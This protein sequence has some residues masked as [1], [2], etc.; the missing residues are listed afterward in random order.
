MDK[1]S[2]LM[3]ATQYIKYLVSLDI[4]YDTVFYL[5]CLKHRRELV[6]VKM[7]QLYGW[8]IDPLFNST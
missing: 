7:Y 3:N 1:Y 5:A 8:D 2:Q 6:A 4:N